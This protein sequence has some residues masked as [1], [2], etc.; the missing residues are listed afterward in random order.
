M[1]QVFSNNKPLVLPDNFSLDFSLKNPMFNDTESYSYPVQIPFDGNR[2]ILS[3]LDSPNS[4]VRPVSLERTPMRINVSGIPVFTGEMQT[5][6]DEELNDS[7]SINAIGGKAFKNLIADLQCRDIPVKDEIL[8]GE[9]LGMVRVYFTGTKKI[10][11]SY[12]SKRNDRRFNEIEH[13]MEYNAKAVASFLPPATGFCIQGRTVPS[14]RIDD[15][16]NYKQ[17]EIVDDYTPII[18]E[19]LESY[20]NVDKPYPFP[21]CNARVAYKHLA[22]GKKDEDGNETTSKKKKID[23]DNPYFVLEADRPAS[24][25]CFYVLYFLDCLF[26][27]LGL[28]WDNSE[29][30]QIE[31]MKRLCFFTTKCSYYEVPDVWRKDA[32]G[33][34]VTEHEYS[35]LDYINEW[36][37]AHGCGSTLSYSNGE[38]E[39]NH[40]MVSCGNITLPLGTDLNYYET[41]SRTD[42]IFIMKEDVILPN[43][44]TATVD[45]EEMVITEMGSET[46]EYTDTFS[47]IDLK[48]KFSDPKFQKVTAE[49]NRMYADSGNFPTDTV[50]SLIES[51]ENQF[52]IRFVY[53]AETHKVTA[54]LLRNMYRNGNSPQKF[55]GYIESVTPVVEKTTGV[56]IC[57]SEE[58]DSKEQKNNIRDKDKKYSLDYDYIDYPD[59]AKP[60]GARGM[61]PA[62]TTDVTKTY[63]DFV[64]HAERTDNTCYID[65]NTGNAFRVKVSGE[66]ANP[67]D[68]QPA[69]FEA[70]GLKGIE[71]G[72]CSEDNEDNVIE[73]TSSLVPTQM[74][75]INSKNVRNAGTTTDPTTGNMAVLEKANQPILAVFLEEDMEREYSKQSLVFPADIRYGVMNVNVEM[76]QRESYDPNTTDSGNSPLQEKEWGLAVSV[77]RGGGTEST[78]QIYDANYDN[79]G[80][81]RWMTTVGT[82]AM[83][84]DSLDT[85]GNEY[86]YNG[87][88]GLGIVGEHFSLKIRAYKT[89]EWAPNG[90]YVD[91]SGNIHHLCREDYIDNTGNKHYIRSRGTGDRFMIEHAHFLLNRRKFLIRG[92]CEA[93]ALAEIP[94]HW[95]ERWQIGDKVGYIDQIEAKAF[96]DT[97]LLEYTITFFEI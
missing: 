63:M 78:M 46:H 56:R 84:P 26:D 80:N 34:D 22:P 53:D 91:P 83:T 15:I 44:G 77:M 37:K 93:I 6:A 75:D 33:N 17:G 35:N 39:E 72:D 85:L 40:G 23:T 66:A 92:T 28:Q 42:Y 7:L 61:V 1:L 52:G 82:Y 76:R 86:D 29:L 48:A 45:L 70:G 74:T 58:S 12:Q 25:V 47:E 69:W 49:Y 8:I 50:T 30:M 32:Q 10:L 81:Y 14:S 57:Y 16:G 5:T 21:Y 62:C 95:T 4:T 31:D 2:H 54:R 43:K 88:N 90:I 73:L 79:C 97:N 64:D 67:E 94:N 13:D 96:N 38:E 36:L 59:P 19:I 60:M 27:Y 55:T 41:G 11:V 87:D 24:G 89:P 68:L 65:A 71:I 18:P 51:L 9:K 20:I 3:N